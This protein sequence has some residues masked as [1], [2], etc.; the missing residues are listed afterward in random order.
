MYYMYNKIFRVFFLGNHGEKEL[1]IM[2][3][4]EFFSGIGSQAKALKNL[5]IQVNILGTSEWDVHAIA[6][7]DVIHNESEMPEYIVDMKK[8]ELLE[9]L[10]EYTFSNSGKTPLE[11]SSF[12]TYSVEVLRR[13]YTSIVRNKNFVDI[14][15]IEG[16]NL[17]ENIDILTYSFPCQ[18]LS[19]VGAFHGFN[20]G[21]DKDSGSRSSLLWQVGR[22]LTE[23]KT[24]NKRLPRFLLME[25]VPTLLSKRHFPNFHTWIKDL[26]ELG[27]ISRYYQLNASSFGIPQNRPRLLMISV[28]VGDNENEK[29]LVQ[30]YFDLKSETDIVSDYCNSTHYRSYSVEE[31]LRLNYSN[32]KIMEEAI[33]CTPN[34]TESRRKIW[35]DNPQIILPD[36][37]FN[38]TVD[39]I[40]TITTKQDRNPNSGNLF[41]DSGIK[42]KS[43]FRYL[44]PRECLLFMGFTDEDYRN[45]KNNNIEFHKGDALFSRDII[46]RMAG[47]SIPVKLLEGVFYQIL[48]IDNLLSAYRN[49]IPEDIADKSYSKLIRSYLFKKGIRSRINK[50]PCP[51]NATVVYPKYKVAVYVSGWLEPLQKDPDSLQIS[52]DQSSVEEANP[53]KYVEAV[54]MGWDAIVISPI[55]FLG[56]NCNVTLEWLEEYLRKSRGKNKKGMILHYDGHKDSR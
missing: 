47:N 17:P 2:N 53:A 10:R 55:K 43:K 14:N 9:L 27:Y 37:T 51:G 4:V 32:K 36:G 5:G 48:Q 31:L 30:N 18:D 38:E 28:Y 16:Q 23:M 44:T 15:S 13:I 24:Y 12:K 52:F 3:L 6:A 34:D 21:I 54:E 22:I 56:M 46:L 40:R 8:D 45:L 42:G 39:S 35:A 11:Y 33:D 1:H 49:R 41:F 7:Y 25:N 29:Q 50:E 20:R 19:N 26:E